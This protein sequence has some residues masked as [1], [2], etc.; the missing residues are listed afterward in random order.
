MSGNDSINRRQFFERT[1]VLGA[2]ATAAL[3]ARKASAQI[4]SAAGT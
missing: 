3:G 1:S 2:A 4:N